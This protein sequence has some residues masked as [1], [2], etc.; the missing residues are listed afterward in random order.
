MICP[1][2]DSGI[3]WPLCPG[4]KPAAWL[5]CQQLS[6]MPF[7]SPLASSQVGREAQICLLGSTRGDPCKL[8]TPLI[9]FPFSNL[10]HSLPCRALFCACSC[11]I[12]HCSPFLLLNLNLSRVTVKVSNLAWEVLKFVSDKCINIL[13]SS[14]FAENCLCEVILHSLYQCKS[15]LFPLF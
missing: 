13:M 6:L 4:Q 14:L 12:W 3:S 2:W 8:I 15:N 9:G 11:L 5:S 10:Q 1:I 7:W